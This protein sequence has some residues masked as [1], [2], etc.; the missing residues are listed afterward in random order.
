MLT[1]RGR[2]RAEFAFICGAI[3][4]DHRAVDT[5]LVALIKPDK[6]G[7][8]FGVDVIDRLGNALAE[9]LLFI[10]VTQFDGLVLAGAGPAGNCRPAHRAVVQNHVH[11]K[12]RIAAGIE[13]LP[14]VNNFDAHGALS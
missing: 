5:F 9:P 6:F 2:I 10:I 4:L 7:G 13:D 14:G 11:F 8:D 3:E 12:R 1:P